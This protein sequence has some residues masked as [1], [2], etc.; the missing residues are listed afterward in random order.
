MSKKKLDLVHNYLKTH[1]IGQE[2]LIQNLIIALITGGHILLEGMPGLA[3]TRSAEALANSIKSQFKR[4]QF[5]PDLLPSDLVGTDIYIEKT[6]GFSF[7]E[8]PLFAN[9][10]L[11]DEVNRSPAKVQSALLEAMGEKQ[12]TVG[13]KTYKLPEVFLVIATQNPVEQ[14]GTYSLPEAQLDRF[15]LHTKISYPSIQEELE[16]LNLVENENGKQ[17]KQ[18][19]IEIKDILNIREEFKK[20]YIDEKLKKY[21]VTL[22]NATREAE[23]YD[24]TLSEYIKYGASPRASISLNITAKAIAYL[25]NAEYVTPDHIQKIAVNILRHRIILNYKAEIDN[26]TAEDIIEKLLKLVAV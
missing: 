3:K 24:K 12:I 4:I 13:K 19:L 22:V 2:E 18:P 20:I 14:E 7:S 15:L 23:K 6:G 21:I 11:A 9:I 5:T 1:I 25:E 8:G 26:V 10:I 17:K 16:I